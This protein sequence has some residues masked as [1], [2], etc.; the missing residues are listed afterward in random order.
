MAKPMQVNDRNFD[1]EVVEAGMP[2]V[3]DFWAPWCGPCKMIGPFLEQLADEYDGKI[4]VVK[5]NTQESNKVAVSLGVRS[6]PAVILFD[7]SEV[8]DAIIGARPKVAFDKVLS[9][10]WKKYEKKMRK[11]EKKRAKEESKQAVA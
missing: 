2:V 1:K 8:V 6:I 11:E 10:Y 9:K 4:K 3:V 5:Y 7:G